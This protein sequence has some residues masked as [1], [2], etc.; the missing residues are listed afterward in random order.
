MKEYRDS[1]PDGRGYAPQLNWA[2]HHYSCHFIIC[3]WLCQTYLH[4]HVETLFQTP[5]KGVTITCSARVKFL[6]H[7]FRWPGQTQHKRWQ[8]QLSPQYP[9]HVT[10]TWS[11]RTFSRGFF[12]SRT[13]CDSTIGS[14]QAASVSNEKVSFSLDIQ[15][16][17]CGLDASAQTTTHEHTTLN[18]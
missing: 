2:H 6:S 10:Q 14:D 12:H 18:L 4:G 3:H 5:M 15:Q 13:V 8:Y 16:K 17:I 1:G 7:I 9:F 11:G